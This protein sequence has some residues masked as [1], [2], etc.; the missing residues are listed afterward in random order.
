MRDRFAQRAERLERRRACRG[1]VANGVHERPLFGAHVD[2]EVH[3]LAA[4]AARLANRAGDLVR[5]LDWRDRPYQRLRAKRLDVELRMDMRR[6]RR[7]ELEARRRGDQPH[8]R[9]SRRRP[10][11]N[12]PGPATATPVGRLKRASSP[13]PS[14]NPG[15]D[16]ATVREEPSGVNR[17]D[18]PRSSV[19]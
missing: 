19:T 7:P 14:R 18:A 17:D 15:I 6:G 12:V 9:V 16:P 4:V 10:R 11:S 5:A 1:A 8:Q 13:G 2:A 3:A